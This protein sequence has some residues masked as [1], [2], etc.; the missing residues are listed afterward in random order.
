[1]DF[2]RKYGEI[3][4]G[5][6]EAHH[7]RPISSLKEGETVEYDIQKDFSVLCSNCHRMI[8]RMEEPSDLVGLRKI[9]RAQRA[10]VKA[11]KLERQ[12]MSKA[13]GE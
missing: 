8:H 5:Y 10:I 12:Q 11:M 6:I 13:V 9:L 7:M 1:M 3:G 4:A 2:G